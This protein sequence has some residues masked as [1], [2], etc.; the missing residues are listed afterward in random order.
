[1]AL[2]KSYPRSAAQI[3]AARLNGRKSRGPVTPQ[4]KRNSSANSL[5]HGLYAVSPVI[6]GE[7]PAA[8]ARLLADLHAT[9]SPSGAAEQLCVYH[10]AAAQWKLLR[11][12]HIE[13]EL[14]NRE[15]DLLTPQT[16]PLPSTP[17]SL[18]RPSNPAPSTSPHSAKST[19]PSRSPS[20]ANY[21]ISSPSRPSA[22]L[23]P[24]RGTVPPPLSIQ[25]TYSKPNSSPTP[26]KSTTKEQHSNE[27]H[28]HRRTR[29][30]TL[31]LLHPRRRIRRRRCRAGP[32]ASPLHLH[33]PPTDGQIFPA[34]FEVVHETLAAFPEAFAA[35]RAA[36][37]QLRA[38]L[39]GYR[40]QPTLRTILT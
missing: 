12:N 38:D 9:Y 26:R 22:P 3:A 17:P 32:F 11:A 10:I 6:K 33:S 35:V 7:S 15:L 30:G 8:F 39:R 19:P 2:L 36:L 20:N 29:R 16:Q 1:M 28:H 5:R 18:S 25:T 24:W 31:P 37:D 27:Q 40:F 21:A 23:T 4:G 34:L 14:I 13:A